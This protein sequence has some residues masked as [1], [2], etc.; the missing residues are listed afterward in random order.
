MAGL[1]K[2][3]LHDVLRKKAT[4][5]LASSS[6]TPASA[7]PKVFLY[8]WLSDCHSCSPIC[9][10]KASK[11]KPAASITPFLLTST[12]P[13]L[14]LLTSCPTCFSKARNPTPSTLPS[15]STPGFGRAKPNSLQTSSVPNHH[16]IISITS[17][18]APTTPAQAAIKRTSSDPSVSSGSSPP[19]SKRLKKETSADKENI[20]QLG[21]K[22]V[23]DKAKAKTSSHKFRQPDTDDDDEPWKKMQLDKERDPWAKLD[24]DF[25]P[26]ILPAPPPTMPSAHSIKYPDLLSVRDSLVFHSLPTSRFLENYRILKLHPSL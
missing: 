19:S 6:T 26:A 12:S 24:R 3:N 18:S 10:V 7:P 14:Q 8:S 22:S 21:S 11:F 2:N 20:L 4:N 15:F 5:A 9:S 25:P 1:T 13:S 16:K 17:D 23:K